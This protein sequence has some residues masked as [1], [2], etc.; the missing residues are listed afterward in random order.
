MP[1]P[2]D[3]QLPMLLEGGNLAPA[4]VSQAFTP[5]LL[6]ALEQAA[7]AASAVATVRRSK[8]MLAEAMEAYR[9]VAKLTAPMDRNEVYKRLQDMLLHFGPPKFEGDIVDA[10][11]AASL[12]NA[13]LDSWTRHLS[14]MTPESLSLAV[15]RWMQGGKPFW[16]KPSELIKLGEPLA[17]EQRKL[18]Y[19][20]KCICEQ[21]P[22][23]TK[24]DR[25]PEEN[26][27]FDDILADFRSKR[28][29]GANVM[30]DAYVQRPAGA[31][32]SSS[33]KE[34]IQAGLRRD[35]A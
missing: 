24:V 33:A 3:A 14:K 5:R 31:P 11:G 25:S 9:H 32:L 19:R 4:T 15:D 7:D 27:K 29:A 23:I 28:T 30:P 18:A 20:L 6:E 17:L 26:A 10:Q 8:G 21:V 35:Q 16:P 2:N 34:M 1:K 12:N 22:K 13:W